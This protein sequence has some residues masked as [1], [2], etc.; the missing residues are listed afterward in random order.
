M[1]AVVLLPQGL[2]DMPGD[3]LP[4]PVRVGAQENLRGVRRGLLQFLDDLGL[5][6]DG[7]VFGLKVVLQ[8]H[9]QLV[10]GQVLDVALAGQHLDFGPQVFLQGPG[11]GGGFDDE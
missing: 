6:Q 9:S 5:P 2:G 4:F 3:G 7:D 1:E 8:V 11:L 10:F